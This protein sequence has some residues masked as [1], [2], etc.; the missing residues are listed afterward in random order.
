[1]LNEQKKAGATV[2]KALLRK[3]PPYIVGAIAYVTSP[4][5]EAGQ[6]EA[7]EATAAA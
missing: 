2:A 7:S 3:L 1:M 4:F 5:E 6:P